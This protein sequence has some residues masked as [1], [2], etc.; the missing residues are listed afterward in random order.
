MPAHVG[1]KTYDSLFSPI[2]DHKVLESNI[3]HYGKGGFLSMKREIEKS[4]RGTMP[5]LATDPEAIKSVIGD[6][7]EYYSGLR[8]RYDPM[9][10]ADT[11]AEKEEDTSMGYPLATRHANHGD[12]LKCYSRGEPTDND[13][14]DLY[15]DLEMTEKLVLE[16]KCPI[17]YWKCMN[18]EDK[19]STKK[20]VSRAFRMVS[21]GSYFLLCLCRRY[22]KIVDKHLKEIIKQFHLVTDEEHYITHVLDRVAGRFSMGVDYTAFDKNS[23]RY[24]VIESMKFLDY[25]SG[26]QTPRPIMEYII[27][28]ISN[29]MT[30]L[31]NKDT[32]ESL[33]YNLN[34][35]NPSGQYHTSNVNSLT[36]LYHNLIIFKEVLRVPIE[37]YLNDIWVIRSC[38]TGD[39]GLETAQ[40]PCELMLR[41]ELLT[42]KVESWFGIPAKVEGLTNPNGKLIPFP[43]D[44]MAPY[45][46][47]VCVVNEEQGFYHLLPSNPKRSL[48]KMIYVPENCRTK[49]DELMTDR[50]RNLLDGIHGI[51]VNKYLNP[52]VPDNIVYDS[53][54]D[55][56]RDY[57]IFPKRPENILSAVGRLPQGQ[58][59]L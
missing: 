55:Y 33:Y 51:A 3:Y 10:W 42:T 25:M 46:S 47:Q 54:V 31:T 1:I 49:F 20:V 29:P 58:I 28:N 19:Y 13:L 35:T 34:A 24:F 2:T 59:R 32:G 41:V 6:M 11:V 21:I 8:I 50:V 38:M 53:M 52:D 4:F 30:V 56:S 18:K 27:L 45:L 12:F 17:S 43:P 15:N 37:D 39:D 23:S 7:Y 5:K 16:G 40:D 14:E 22:L 48:A 57:G 44:V 26:Y 9:S 36:H